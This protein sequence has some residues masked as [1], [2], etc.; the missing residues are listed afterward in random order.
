MQR[1]NSDTYT[2]KNGYFMAPTDDS[3]L[4]LIRLWS[5]CD[6][7]LRREHL[8]KRADVLNF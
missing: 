2:D 5:I 8:Y 4:N 7:H 6:Y 1:D 3:P